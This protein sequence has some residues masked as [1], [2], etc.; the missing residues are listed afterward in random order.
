MKE[1]IKFLSLATD[2][3]SLTLHSITKIID[4]NSLGNVAAQ[5]KAERERLEQIGRFLQK[6]DGEDAQEFMLDMRKMNKRKQKIT[7]YFTHCN[8][9]LESITSAHS[10]RHGNIQSMPSHCLVK[11]FMRD[12]KEYMDKK[13]ISEREYEVPSK[14]TVEKAFYVSNPYLG[15]TP[16]SM[17]LKAVQVISQKQAHKTHINEHACNVICRITKDRMFFFYQ[18][19][20]KN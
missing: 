3:T 1:V 4:P 19:K 10:R 13:G 15:V 2:L 11:G 6:E 7:E 18:N 5:N 17:R 20:Y 14:S 8:Q 12:V 9:Y 16:S